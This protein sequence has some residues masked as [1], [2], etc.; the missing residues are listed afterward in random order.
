VR[1]RA[2]RR[3]PRAGGGAGSSAAGR[4]P[5]A[6][7]LGPGVIRRVRGSAAALAAALLVLAGCG[8]EAPPEAGAGASAVDRLERLAFVPAGRTVRATGIS[9][10]SAEDLLVDRF[11][12]T[13]ALWDAM[14]PEP[15]AVPE[16]FRPG[17]RFRA[18]EAQP[19]TW[20]NDVPVVG[21]TPVE[22]E[23]FAAVRGMRLPTFEEWM[24]CAIGPLARPTPSGQIQV[25]VANTS[26]VGLARP[27]PV[28]SF[29][30]GRTPDTGLYDMLGNVWEWSRAAADGAAADWAVLNTE[31]WSPQ[32]WQEAPARYVGG[33]FL[34]PARSL[35]SPRR[36]DVYAHASTLGQRSS[37]VGFRCVAPARAYL[38]RIAG[39][40]LATGERARAVAIGARWGGRSVPSLT[41][42]L[43]EAEASPL[44]EAILEGARR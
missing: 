4:H 6:V 37:D 17:R 23:A 36:G 12:V 24:W 22:A 16:V 43:A 15:D 33:S 26:E 32:R 10:G 29:E 2:A 42:A 27:A 13:W 28:G 11:E 3:T 30:S 39:E 34:T 25:N 19:E 5:G 44:L 20:I 35:Y 31:S 40:E 9:V 41:A 38:V 1:T 14:S 21:V 7:R 8:G 18:P